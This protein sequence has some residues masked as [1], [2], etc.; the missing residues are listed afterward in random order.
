LVYQEFLQ[1]LNRRWQNYHYASL[2]HM[3]V[4]S[5]LIDLLNVQYIVVDRNIPESR[6]DHRALAEGRVE[7]YRD[8]DVIIYE[9]PTAL[10]RAWVV[11]DVRPATNGAASLVVF[12]SGE[13]DGGEVALVEGDAPPVSPPED[14]RAAQVTVS[15]WTP[16]GMTLEVDHSGEGLLVVSQVY[17][18]G[19]K[20]TVDGEEVAVLQTDHALVGIPIGPGEHEVRLHYEPDS[21]VIGLW[22]SGLSGLGSMA[23]L[24]YAA[25]AGISRRYHDVPT[26]PEDDAERR[27]R[28]VA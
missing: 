26:G 19:W 3:G 13:A 16:D 22:I 27:S 24:G 17:S 4:N 8:E 23:I 6:A 28:H 12:A 2:V 9:V 5:P 10:P 20:A 15:R 11:Y 25:W 7:V 18:E 1:V 14:G 21:L